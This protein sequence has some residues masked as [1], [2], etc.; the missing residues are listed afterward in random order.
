MDHGGVAQHG[1]FRQRTVLVAQT[2]GVGDDLSEVR[3]TG[4]L[5]VACEGQHI[6]QLTLGSHR[7]E[8]CLQSLSYL[9]TGGAG[10]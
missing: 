9:L 2:D 7:L 5:A 1:H 10:E 3:M 4:G 8:L 6:R